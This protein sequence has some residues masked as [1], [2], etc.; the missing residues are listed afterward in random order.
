MKK[1][2][3]NETRAIS[4]ATRSSAG[5]KVRQRTISADELD[6]IFSGIG[7]KL[8]EGKSSEAERVL[9]EVIERQGLS[10]DD[11]AN[12][13]RLLAF[14]F[15][16]V[17]RYK[18]SLEAIKPYE[19]EEVLGRV[20]METQVRI[21]TQLA[22]SFNNLGDHPK[23]VTLLKSTLENAKEN[24]LDHLLGNIDIGLARVYRKLNEF[25]I[26]R[27]YAKEALDHLRAQGDWL[28]IAEAYREIALSY[29]Q[30]GNSENALEYFDLGIQIIGSRSAP[31][32][33]CLVRRPRSIRLASQP[34]RVPMRRMYGVPMTD[35][36]NP[37]SRSVRTISRSPASRIARL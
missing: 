17:G 30:E 20:S 10:Q 11:L 2:P 25:A 14:T 13:K 28:G 1:T 34:A 6:A 29:H 27:D 37:V 4:G 16:T 8:R 26:C 23:A 33:R 9:T 35:T 5:V 32:M 22:I 15:E 21:T 36:G 19:D 31:F 12:L 24:G 7:Q 18:A 3:K